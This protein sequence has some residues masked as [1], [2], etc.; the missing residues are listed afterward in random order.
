ML[1]GILHTCKCWHWYSSKC[2]H[3]QFMFKP[4]AASSV[5][6]WREAPRELRSQRQPWLL[7]NQI[8]IASQFTNRSASMH[9]ILPRKI[10]PGWMWWKETSQRYNAS[11][12]TRSMFLPFKAHNVSVDGQACGALLSEPTLVPT[13]NMDPSW[14]KASSTFITK[15]HLTSAGKNIKKSFLN[16]LLDDR[17]V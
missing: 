8:W 15:I 4:S 16:I 11:F 5:H 13:P 7:W 17:D 3:I 10:F 14:C 9:L 12:S 1:I 6:S 2:W